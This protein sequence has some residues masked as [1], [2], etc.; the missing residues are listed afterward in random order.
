MISNVKTD[1]KC[2]FSTVLLQ[3]SADQGGFSRSCSSSGSDWSSGRDP[4]RWTRPKTLQWRRLQGL[5]SASRAQLGGDGWRT[6]S[7]SLSGAHQHPR[8][9]DP[10]IKQHARR[11]GS[12]S[13]PPTAD[14]TARPG[15][16]SALA[17]GESRAITASVLGRQQKITDNAASKRSLSP[18]LGATRRA[19]F[20]AGSRDVVRAECA[21][22]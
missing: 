9:H 11:R 7:V 19:K 10:K 3:R 1:R 4:A 21:S 8:P 16:T 20:A 22:V 17:C 15:T 6:A 5:S 14:S 2:L 12:G 18:G 13:L